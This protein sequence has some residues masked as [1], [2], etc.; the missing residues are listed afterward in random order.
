LN[1]RRIGPA[2]GVLL[3]LAGTVYWLRSGTDPAVTSV[4]AGAH[5]GGRL[6]VAYRTEPKSFNRY[7]S[8]SVHEQLVAQLT[9]D[10][11]VRVN[12]AT[13]QLEPRLATEWTTTDGR[14]WTLELR[15]GVH[16]SDGTAFTAADVVFSFEAL[17]DPTAKSVLADSFV[18]DGSPILVRA[19]DS[20]TVVLT[21][22]SVY[23]PGLSLLA[24][25]PI[26]PRHK[27][28]PALRAGTFA[29]AWNT[30]TDPKEIVGLGPF[31]IEA[32]VPG[33]RLSFAR[34][35]RFWR[36]DDAGRPLPYLDAVELQIVPDHNAEM[37][38]LQAGEVDLGTDRVRPEDVAAFETLRKQ[39]KID[40]LRA[41]VSISPDMLWFN[42]DP[43]ST[44][45][46]TR[47]WLQRDEL[48][49]A[50]SHAV[51]RQA[52]VDTV[53]LGA[54]EP[55]FGPITPGHTEW[56][57]P[58]LPRTEPNLDKARALLGELGLRDA[59]GDGTLED[60]RGQ[61]ARF[62]VT[63]QKG[64]TIR[65]RTAAMVQEQVRRVGLVMDVV[66][67]ERG[68]MID[69]W[70]RGDYDAILFAVEYDS[71]DP[72]APFWRSSGSWHFWHPNQAAPA[73]P[74]EAR[75]DALMTQQE[76]ALDPAERRRL[77]AEAQREF[78]AHMPVLY[79]A[80]PRVFVA[81]SARLRGV[82]PSVLTP[83]VLWNA[84]ML[85]LAAPIDAAARH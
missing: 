27:L 84:E 42:L 21:L 65:E 47:P 52:I 41:G 16:F 71:F 70:S 56:F 68:V 34:N 10:T 19:V 64:H 72:V 62:A 36:R 63:T 53:F 55:V 15:S 4:P 40:L 50:I 18:I 54:A 17:Y 80:A 12:R 61:P 3:A 43:S 60:A 45:A 28:E 51:D 35:P 85:S 79:F 11:L 26:L 38:R 75:I 31:S 76:R 22:P 82:V 33:Q 9:Q 14:S 23:A 44:H 25:L 57:V 7:I 83:P 73:T 37:L 58:D 13:G 32:Y 67:V 49:L 8:A 6:L 66:P 78:V 77:F 29:T 30:A 1:L 24:S 20:D 81:A 59:D 69:Q 74:W 46:R 5:Q 39:G 48:R 2:V